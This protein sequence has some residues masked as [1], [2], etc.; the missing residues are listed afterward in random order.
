MT[1]FNFAMDTLAET[2]ET[3]SHASDAMLEVYSRISGLEKV[4]RLILL[5]RDE[6]LDLRTVLTD[7]VAELLVSSPAL[8]HSR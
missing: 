7:N 3:L 1:Y 4:R 2:P 6:E 8:G 5:E